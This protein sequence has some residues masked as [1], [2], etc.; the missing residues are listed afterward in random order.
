MALNMTSGGV[1]AH[2]SAMKDGEI[3]DIPQYK[4]W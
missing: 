4:F 2:Q 3:M 1:V